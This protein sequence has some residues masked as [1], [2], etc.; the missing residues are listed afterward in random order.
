MVYLKLT[1]YWNGSHSNKLFAVRATRKVSC[2]RP[3]DSMTNDK[4]QRSYLK[5]SMYYLLEF[6]L[7]YSSPVSHFMR[8][9]IWSAHII[10]S[11][12]NILSLSSAEYT[13]LSIF[14]HRRYHLSFLDLKSD[15]PENDHSAL[16][17]A[18]ITIEQ[19]PSGQSALL[20]VHRRK[21]NTSSNH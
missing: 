5:G 17:Q 6:L 1:I 16:P 21:K 10:P 8:P 19:S 4:N 13:Y 12:P 18:F 15:I 14:K 11:A 20:L 3:L 2:Q 7:I 9:F